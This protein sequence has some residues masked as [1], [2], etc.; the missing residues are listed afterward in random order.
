MAVLRIRDENGNITDIATIRGYSAYQVARMNGFE[1]TQEEWLRS[2]QGPSGVYTGAGEMPEG[3]EVQID[4]D[5]EPYRY[6][7][8]EEEKDE[9]ALRVYAMLPRAEEASL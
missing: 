7:L 9:I 6:T 1:G 2:L 8:T 5:G 4:P 3:Y